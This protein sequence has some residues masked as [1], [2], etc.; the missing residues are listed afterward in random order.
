MAKHN[1]RKRKHQKDGKQKEAEQRSA[2]FSNIYRVLKLYKCDEIF[3]LLNEID[4]DIIFKYRFRYPKLVAAKGKKL[5]PNMLCDMKGVLYYRLKGKMM[6]INKNCSSISLMDYFTHYNT[7]FF[8]YQRFKKKEE[9]RYKKIAKKMSDRFKFDEQCGESEDEG[10]FQIFL[11]SMVFSELEGHLYRIN[12]DY[13]FEPYPYLELQVHSTKPEVISYTIDGNNRPLYRVG[14][15]VKDDFQWSALKLKNIKLE[16]Y[17]INIPVDVYIQSHALHRLEERIDCLCYPFLQYQL[18]ITLKNPEIINFEGNSLL[19]YKINDTKYGYFVLEYIE[20]II[21]IKTFLFLT[22]NGT[23]EGKKLKEISGLNKLDKQ[24]WAIDKLSTFLSK[25][26]INNESLKELF[27]EAGCKQL[28]EPLSDDFK[29][30]ET[31]G[32][33]DKLMKYIEMEQKHPVNPEF[34]ELMN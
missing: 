26:F 11:T 25:E 8:T 29:L 30:K 1:K 23:P 17:N 6:E 22:N 4:R 27:T 3:T 13:K 14:W 24:Y 9:A 18:Y 33:A 21:V 32:V 12:I 5:P 34:V 15:G 19:E 2:F 20:G 28:F 7:L 16:G 31:V 10:S